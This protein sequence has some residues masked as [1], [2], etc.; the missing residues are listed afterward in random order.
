[1]E[2]NLDNLVKRKYFFTSPLALHYI[3]VPLVV[4]ILYVFFGFIRL[5]LVIDLFD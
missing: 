3:K 4:F 1:M 2:K 5:V